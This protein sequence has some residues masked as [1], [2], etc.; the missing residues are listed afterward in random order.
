M[1]EK[2]TASAARFT[3]PILKRKHNAPHEN[4]SG[5]RTGEQE[6][7]TKQRLP[8]ILFTELYSFP[9][10]FHEIPCTFQPST[11]EKVTTNKSMQFI[12]SPRE[13]IME[14]L[15][16]IWEFITLPYITLL[17]ILG[18]VGIILKRH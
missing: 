13:K 3:P 2:P 7:H 9:E 10:Q 1:R 12:C 4:G 16:A 14:L 15:K 17:L 6:K 5:T 8:D 18:I 11:A